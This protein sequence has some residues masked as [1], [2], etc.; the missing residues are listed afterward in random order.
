MARGAGQ[1]RQIGGARWPGAITAN[2][3][4][5][6]RASQEYS[7]RLGVLYLNQFQAA[8][9]RF[10][11]GT[12]VG[13]ERVPFGNF[14]QNVFLTTT[15][16]EYVL[17][18]APHYPWQ[19]PKE[20]FFTE[21]LH[22]GTSVPVPW[23]YLL[24]PADDIFGWSYAIMPRMPGVQLIDPDVRDGLSAEDRRGIAHAMG[25]T[26]AGLHTLSWHCAG[27]YD[28]ETD[29]IKPLTLGYA[30]WIASRIHHNLHLAIP[31][32]DRTTEADAEWV[33]ELIARG[34]EALAVPFE[35]RFVMEDYKEGNAV[36]ECRDGVWQISGVFD[37]ME[38]YFG[39][40]E[41]DL[42]R[43]I[44]VYVDDD[45]ELARVFARAYAESTRSCGRGLRPGF[46]DRFPVYML[47]D[48]LIIWQFGQRHG[49]WWDAGLT[50]RE[51]ADPYVSVA[52]F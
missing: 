18:G 30:E 50:L 41:T 21:L 29:T 47:L 14:G 48:R 35:P 28:L 5:K 22:Q 2:Q 1:C 26:L 7:K 13:T 9:D 42:S 34:R 23:P 19:F 17:R 49:V 32:S 46:A 8:L 52:V 10:D 25:E 20:R 43:S 44:A 12:L 16:G 40:C 3:E 27:E 51:W 6:V 38:P 15:R 31:L 4:K 11:L 39:D 24:D 37:Y 45:A 33:E 36:A